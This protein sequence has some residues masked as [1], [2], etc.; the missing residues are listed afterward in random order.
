MVVLTELPDVL[1]PGVIPSIELTYRETWFTETGWYLADEVDQV[2]DK[3]ERTISTLGRENARLEKLVS[4]LK[5]QL[6]IERS[7]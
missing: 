2:L 1:V 4:R 5:D 6:I 3:A 7:R